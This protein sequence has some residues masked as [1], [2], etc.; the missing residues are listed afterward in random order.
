MLS[1]VYDDLY[2]NLHTFI[3]KKHYIPYKILSTDT[4]FKEGNRY[5]IAYY[6]QTMKV[7]SIE[8]DKYGIMEYCYVKWDDGNYGAYCS[9]LAIFDDYLMELD[10]DFLYKEEDIINSPNI[11]TGA[12]IKYWLFINNI[13]ATS[14]KYG[15][16]WE[17][18]EDVLKVADNDYKKYKLVGTVNENNEY[19]SVKI[20]KIDVTKIIP[21]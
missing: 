21:A 13:T 15:K 12:E 7:I 14:P 10:S 11:Y 5:Y 19:I 4:K 1:I 17:M 8:Y 18:L 9:N 3:R 2:D 6:R 20:S 16:I